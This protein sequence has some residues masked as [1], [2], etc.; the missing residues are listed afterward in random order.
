MDFQCLALLVP[1]VRNHLWVSCDQDI[2]FHDIKLHIKRAHHVDIPV[3]RG[4]EIQR[5]RQ[6][7]GRDGEREIS[8]KQWKKKMSKWY[9]TYIGSNFTIKKQ[10]KEEFQ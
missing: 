5:E 4:R 3:E 8:P 1:R 7:L 2:S 9:L 10:R 6:R